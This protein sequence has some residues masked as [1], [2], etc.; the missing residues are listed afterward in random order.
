M[1]TD[2][3]ETLIDHVYS[4]VPENLTETAVPYLSVSAHFPVCFS[5]KMNSSCPTGPVHKT[6]NYRDTK[7]F[8]E[9]LFLQNLENSPW[10]LIESSVDANEALDIFTT[11]FLSDLE[12]HVPKKHAV[13]P[14]W[15]NPE[16]LQAIKPR[17]KYKK[18]KNT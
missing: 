15:I 12:T 17:G 2:I 14:K 11:L 7:Y 16:S 10:F 5:R 18:D 9:T 4:N 6:I 13:Q 8:D 3:S 1:V